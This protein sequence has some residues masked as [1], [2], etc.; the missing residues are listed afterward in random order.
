MVSDIL[1][2]VFIMQLSINSPKAAKGNYMV[3][4]KSVMVRLEKGWEVNTKLLRF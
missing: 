3:S 4:L 1:L 2:A